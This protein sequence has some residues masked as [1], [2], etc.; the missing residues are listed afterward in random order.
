VVTT[1]E[2]NPG[3]VWEEEELF[4]ELSWRIDPDGTLDIRRHFESPYRPGERMTLD[5]KYRWIF[6]TAVPGLPEAAAEKGLTPLEYMRRFGAFEVSR[7][8]YELHG[9][10]GFATPSKKIEI[11]S[12]TLAEWGWP[13]HTMP[14]A[15]TSHVARSA[16]ETDEMVLV[17]TFRLPT[18]IHSRSANSEWLYEISHS[19]PLW[20]HPADAERRSIGERDLVRVETEIGWFVLRPFLTEGLLPGIVACSHHLGRWHLRADGERASRW[21]SAEVDLCIDGDLWRWRRTASERQA[22]GGTDAERSGGA[23]RRWWREAGVHQNMAFPVHPDPASGMHC[24]H[25]KVKVSRAA[26]DDRFGDVVVD[27]AKARL[28]QEEWRRL[29]RPAHGELRRPLW[30]PRSMRP[31]D[32]AYRLPRR[33]H[34]RS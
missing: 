31:E 19:N 13:E 33:P 34:D 14:E 32:A 23:G 12:P 10:R 26:R 5:E 18:L 25:Q 8:L 28:V 17:P 9:E 29:A 3:E 20:I 27:R 24:W 1:R 2:T 22:G 6:E 21:G 7:E 30:L 4:L 11:A 16:L 15:I